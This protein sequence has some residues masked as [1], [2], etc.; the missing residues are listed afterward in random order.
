MEDKERID[1]L[2][3]TL[4]RYNYEYYILDNPTVDDFTY[5]RL[6][7]E[8][9]KLE[10][11]HPEYKRKDSPTERVGS[12]VISS[13]TKVEHKIPMLSLSDVFN[14]DEIIKFDERI[15]KEGF[16]PHY[17]V[18]LKIDGLAISL[19][20]ENGVL[21]RGVTRG[22]GVVGEDITHNVKTIN[23][24][25]LRIKKPISIEVRGEI[26]I[27]KAELLRVNKER[28]KEGLPLFQNCR[29]LASGSVR[30]LDSSVAKSRKLNN[31]IYHLPNPKDYGVY[32]HEKAM[33]FME[34]LGFKVNEKRKY[35]NNINEV[36]SFIEDVKKIRAELPYDIDG[37]V[38][39]V[40]DILMQD[41]LGYTAKSPKWATAYKFPPEEVVTKLKDIKFTVGRTGKITPNAILE[42]VRVA[43]S[44]ISRA[45]LNNEDFIKEKDIRVGDYVILRKAGDVI[46]E[47]VGVKFDKR[48]KGLKEF[49]MIDKCPICGSSIVRNENEAHYFCLN[50]N[51]DA[52][53][54]SKII[55][56]V[57]RKAMNI[58]GFGERIA[59]DFY[60]FGYI[61]NITD[62]YKLKEK[63]EDIKEI[64]GFGEKS[65]NNLLN[66]I[67]KS[68]EA[69]LE[70]L[71]F[72]IGIRHMGEKTAKIIAKE[73][74]TM[75]K[76]M[77]ATYDEL[78]NITDIGVILAKSIVSY[79]KDEENIKMVEELKNLGLNMN[80]KGKIVNKNEI[81]NDKKFVITGTIPFIQREKLK[82]V[83]TSFGGK[84]I[85]S[86]SSKTDV[87]I[88]GDN[89]GSK[90]DKA[91]ELNITIWDNDTLKE[92]LKEVGEIYE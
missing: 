39:K 50:K 24:I 66:A 71:L 1:Y 7:D 2:V 86:V 11:K 30:Q 76:L 70:R 81:F 43:G 19:T 80:Y 75:D 89:P 54:I 26:Y 58:D 35:C 61:K 72:G 56:F 87:L 59:E 79:F 9:I 91:K 3:D 57:S 27:K 33:E 42:P 5:D 83:I 69:S 53:N 38:I 60:N 15:K 64:E 37:M 41:A 65:V 48:E 73:Y 67:E 68:K 23:D 36:I 8:L 44:T 45:T 32:S 17:V 6:I 28:E 10:N 55:H 34:D 20:Y 14:E 18:E 62:I 78:L 16:T 82:E 85:D 51:C 21:V 52:K 49:K 74:P 46:P 92:K 31:F 4:N 29:N 25:P 63:E 47:V 13:F 40:D 84:A 12:T 22:D 90:Y 88:K 77:N